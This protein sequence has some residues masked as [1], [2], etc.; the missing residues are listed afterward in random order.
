MPQFRV[1][2]VRSVQS[3]P[4]LRRIND[5][6]LRLLVVTSQSITLSLDSLLSPLSGCLRL[7]TLGIH[8]LL[9]YPLT[10][11][12]SLGLVDLEAGQYLR[13]TMIVVD[14]RVQREHACA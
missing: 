3:S 14:I 9:E 6:L 5:L 13:V 10:L 7:R 11:L 8:L 1:N 2:E 12:L 4:P